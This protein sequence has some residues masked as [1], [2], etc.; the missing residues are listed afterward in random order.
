VCGGRGR[1]LSPGN[2]QIFF[3]VEGTREGRERSIEYE[4]RGEEEEEEE[5]RRRERWRERNR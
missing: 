3:P 4:K 5:R 2:A 1:S